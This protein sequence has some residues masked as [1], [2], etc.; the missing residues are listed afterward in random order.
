MHF[1]GNGVMKKGDVTYTYGSGKI[2]CESQIDI[3]ENITICLRSMTPNAT[4]DFV[5]INHQN[6]GKVLLAMMKVSEETDLG[7]KEWVNFQELKILID[8]LPVKKIT[9]KGDTVYSKGKIS[10]IVDNSFWQ[11]TKES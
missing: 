4:I 9:F 1:N 2:K 6:E 11:N 3:Y 7:V 5:K 8:P 10:V